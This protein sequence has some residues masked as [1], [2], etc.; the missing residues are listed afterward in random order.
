MRAI[1][2]P[3]GSSPIRAARPGSQDRE[4]A[5]GNNCRRVGKRFTSRRPGSPTSSVPRRRYDA[6]RSVQPRRKP[7]SDQ[8]GTS[9]APTG[10]GPHSSRL[11]S[12]DPTR[13]LF[14]CTL[15]GPARGDIEPRFPKRVGGSATRTGSRSRSCGRRRRMLLERRYRQRQGVATVADVKTHQKSIRNGDLRRFFFVVNSSAATLAD[16][17]R[18]TTRVVRGHC[19]RNSPRSRKPAL[20]KIAVLAA[21]ST[22]F[23]WH[24]AQHRRRKRCHQPRPAESKRCRRRVPI[25]LWNDPGKHA[26]A[27]TDRIWHPYCC[28]HRRR[29]HCRPS[30][31]KQRLYGDLG[32]GR[33]CGPASHTGVLVRS[34]FPMG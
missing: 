13:L 29:W 25:T 10:V 21:A 9:T 1:G 16:G 30:G 6:A 2:L 34:A 18:S 24:I 32:A 23:T 3:W 26:D 7:F 15:R 4:S 14:W 27:T 19:D 5:E 20:D 33:D 31:V 17:L 11:P 12:R 28:A 22:K 8:N